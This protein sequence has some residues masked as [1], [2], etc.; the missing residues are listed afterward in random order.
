M[1]LNFTNI[2]DGTATIMLYKDLGGFDGI[3]GSLIAQDIHWMNEYG[4][5]NPND[6]PKT[7]EIKINSMGGNV[8]DG[9]SICNAILSS[10]IPV[11]TNIVGMAY[12]MAGVVA[13]CGTKK[14]MSDYA[15]FM[16]HNVSGGDNEQVLD[17]LTNSLA[18][19]FERTTALNIDYCK[20]LMNKETWMSADECL[21]MGL[22]DE[23]VVTKVKKPQ[24]TNGKE[25]HAF[26]NKL[27][28]KKEMIKLTNLLKLSNEASEDA[29]VEKVE[30]ISAEKDAALNELLQ[31]KL[32]KIALEAKIAAFEDIENAKESEAVESAVNSAVTEGKIGADSKQDWLDSGLTSKRLKAL[33]ASFKTIPA[34]TPPFKA[35]EK[36]DGNGEDRSTW[37]FSDWEKKDSK[38][39]AEIQANNSVEFERLIKT[40]DTNFKS[41]K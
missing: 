27:I 36:K 6:A 16:M 11:T 19:I 20:E 32:D 2:S 41:K 29:I 26:Y 23:I 17:L 33:F 9:L 14:K 5:A 37:T 10:S 34:Y 8:Q 15:T 28:T 12:S 21:K 38:G 4:V 22:I 40:I 25:L 31:L 35:D 1:K 7:I 18:T 24:M 13:M 39:L 30:T 3:D